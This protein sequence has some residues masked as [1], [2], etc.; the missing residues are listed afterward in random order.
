LSI[1]EEDHLL[2]GVPRLKRGMVSWCSLTTP[3]RQ[4]MMNWAAPDGDDS[5][6]DSAPATDGVRAQGR[7]GLGWGG[8]GSLR[9]TR[10]CGRALTRVVRET[11]RRARVSPA[12]RPCA[13]Q[14]FDG[15]RS[16][17]SFDLPH[18]FH[19]IG[20]RGN[21]ASYKVKTPVQTVL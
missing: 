12:L 17:L 11:L 14:S 15:R 5:I 13:P 1:A 4:L 9:G 6:L 3:D 20:P 7:P 21:T 10:A 18:A 2:L 8:C 16:I 19:L